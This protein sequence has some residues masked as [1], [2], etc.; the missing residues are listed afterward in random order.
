APTPPTRTAWRAIRPASPAPAWT[1]W[2]VAGR[3]HDDPLGRAAAVPDPRPAGQHPGVPEPVA[4]PGA[5]AAAG[6]AG[7]R[8]AD[9]AGGAD[10]VPVGRQVRA[11]GD[12]PAPGIG[13]DRRRH[14][15]VPD[16]H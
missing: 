6:G 14:R 13:V 10:A 15:P 4:A 11:G 1:C 2:P 12:A 9:R 8:T 3:A 16:R 5:G 7:A